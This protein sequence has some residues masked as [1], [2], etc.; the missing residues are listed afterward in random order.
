MRGKWLVGAILGVLL[1][2]GSG[3]ALA[4]ADSS[5]GES[6]DPALSAA[7]EESPG[8]E[9]PADRTATSDTF[10]LPDGSREARIYPAPV[11]YKAPGGE[12]KPIEEGLEEEPDGSGYTNGANAFDLSLPE[13]VG[14]APVRLDSGEGWVSAR[15]LGE[16]SEAA[17]VQGDTA[18]YEG[19]DPATS[20]EYTSTA[21]G[22]KEAIEL[23]D[24]SAPASY[25]FELKAAP[26][27]SPSLEEDGSIVFRDEGEKA[28]ATL[29]AP[30]VSDSSPGTLP[31]SHAVHYELQAEGEGS[32][33]LS[34]AVDPAWLEGPQRSFPAW[35]DP[36][37]EIKKSPS[38]DC[39]YG[40]GFSSSCG[41]AGGR[42][43]FA[44]YHPTSEWRRS[45]LRFDLGSIP[46]NAYVGTATVALHAQAAVVNT[47]GLELRRVTKDWTSEVRWEWC[48][49]FCQWSA[50]G[51]DY[52][53]EG[54]EVKTSERGSQAGWWNFSAG[55]APL[56]QNWVSGTAA[57]QGLLLKL[58]QDHNGECTPSCV[59]R[60]A[61]FDSSAATDSNN[62]PYMTVGY[63][64]PAPSTSKVASPN[65]GTQ[66]A[67]RFKLKAAWSAAGVTGVT[68]QFREKGGKEPFQTIPSELVKDAQGKEVKWPAPLS[69]SPSQPLY[70]DAAHATSALKSHGGEI[71]LR[72]LFEGP[73]GAGGYS[74]PVDVTVDR[75]VGGTHDATTQVGPGSL[76]LLTG[77]FTVSRTD[78]A[79]AGFGSAL[80]FNRTLS[81]RD[82]ESGTKTVLGQGWKPGAMVEIAGGSE[83]RSVREFTP[84]GEEAAEGVAPYA[85]LT[86]LEGYEY[87]FEKSG[88]T[89]ITPPELAGFTLWRQDSTHLTLTDSDANR[90]T[91]ELQ[92]GEYLPVSVSQTGGAGNKT[93][94]VYELAEGNR[95]LSM[96]IAPTAAG[97]TCP[98]GEGSLSTAGCRVLSFTYEPGSTWGMPA[99]L[100]PR[101]GRI[102][103]Y[104]PESGTVNGHWEVARY[105]Y[106]TKGQLIEEWDPRASTLVEKYTYETG[107]QLH[108]ITPPG[109]EPWT[110]EYGTYDGEQA[111]GRLVAVK[112]PSLVA[113]PTVAQTTIAYGVPVSGSGAPYEMGSAEVA[114]WGQQDLPTD[115]TAVFPP[116]EVPAKPPT[117]Y[118]R[119]SLYYMD[120]EGQLINT[121]TPSGAGTSAPSIM[122][123]EADEHGNVVRELSAQNRLR[124]LAAG[125][126]SVK[127]SEELETK[128]HF[129]AEGTQMEE[130]WGPMHQVRLE[131]GETVQARLHRTVQYDEGAPTPPPGTPMPHLPTRETTG[132]S[133]PGHGE[134]AE[135]HVTKTEYNWPLRQPTE[136]ITDP[137]GLELKTRIAYDPESGLSTERSL[138]AKPEGGDAHTTKTIY[139]SAGENPADHSCGGKPGWANLPCKITPAAQPGTKGLPELPVTKILAYN[140]LGEATETSESPGGS[141]ENVRKTILTYDS[142]GR[143]QTKKVEGG[144]TAIPKVESLYSSTNGMPTEKRFVCEVKCEGFDNQATITTYDALGRAKEYLDADGSLS[145]VTYDLDGRPVTSS[146]GKGTQTRSY[147]STTG[148]LTKLE[149]SA[150]GTFTAAY[151]AN[152]AMTEEGLPNGL[153]ATTTFNE[154]G[155]PTKLAYVKATS[156]SEKCT[157]LE[158]SNERSIY[159][160]VLSQT[161]LSSTQQYSYDKAGRLILTKDTPTGGS[162][163]TRSYN[164]D[165]DSN[166][167]KLITRAPGIGGACDTSSEGTPQEYKYDAGDRL[168][169]EG[170][171][172]DSW[173]RITSLPAK[174][175][176][177]STLTTT[178]Y[179][180]D[181]VATQ[182][183]GGLTNSYQLDSTGRPRE[184]K[185]TGAKELTEVFHYAGGSDSPAWTARGS[186]WTRYI[187]GIEGELAAV[188]DSS[189]G[190][191]LELHDL[192]G[193]V[194]A[195]ASLSPTAKEPTA[196]F[197]FDEFG[198]PKSG[199][200]GRFGWL[201]GKQRRTELASG[202]IQMGVRTY[203]PALGRFL[204]RDPV[205][206]GSANAYDYADQDP[207]NAFDLGGESKNYASPRTPAKI[208]ERNLRVAKERR[209]RPFVNRGCEHRGCAIKDF[210]H[211]AKEDALDVVGGLVHKVLSVLTYRSPA[212]VSSWSS[213]KRLVRGYI[214]SAS[215]SEYQGLWSCAKEG[216][217]GWMETREVAG[218]DGPEGAVAA[219]GWVATR[220][221][222]GWL[223]A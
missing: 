187:G 75:F 200:A 25:G 104:G 70:F 95:R 161:S 202:V 1:L 201:G 193:D 118:T 29:P 49:P 64:M 142:A 14:A 32:W 30:T 40:N 87:A 220:C 150:A 177:G 55:L 24:A 4:Q 37:V 126:E 19:Q 125:S 155:Q 73:E 151:D 109:Q 17:E 181:M 204:S 217:D 215:Q 93:R 66:T 112:R 162:C 81:S 194:V 51:G 82:A 100:G 195:T 139:Y 60:E 69:T 92:G 197:E 212:E 50:P 101:L 27:L 114:K 18:T 59:N 7:P 165:K 121:A 16:T 79:I 80:E 41:F 152:G 216:Y 20:F 10:R 182:S 72:A 91:F 56:V 11:N 179:S 102:F 117:A 188:Q 111:N 12:W 62:R 183:Q 98:E 137:G 39:T 28:F 222:V 167:T 131:S 174:D 170:T 203:V 54:S 178:F 94:M 186:A 154:V 35:I 46:K 78:V 34:V 96:M 8:V 123:T 214:Q 76:D 122:T 138:P 185:V 97:V 128:R 205:E 198:N 83:W 26:G 99:E 136:T 140:S 108:T 23:A 207:V 171:T 168:I 15:L 71:Q 105:K 5:D 192:H 146:D 68:Y 48:S 115:A 84:S 218:A 127:R 210:A 58:T 145:T 53:S 132:A 219:Y 36:S 189:A 134:D 6:T 31:D 113:S 103:Y 149:D 44:T 208:R 130:E 116:D 209:F 211:V 191:S 169:D 120:A 129:N 196:K 199:T 148:L 2:L 21:D 190:T 57:N 158:E 61:T 135:I 157:W 65:A 153:V 107:G 9:I 223:G 77:N 33:R 3:I 85:I 141:A 144:G 88:E 74:V 38:L 124:A 143:E 180:S 164:Y 89:F 166:R 133:I 119:A 47:A 173:G 176:G 163:T 184:L 42:E 43:L 221:V 13:R 175:A 156:C 213:M 147:D 67:R 206:G 90:T 110:M 86:D 63:Y 52:T 106:N 160:Q 45:L 172:Y 159:G 22:V